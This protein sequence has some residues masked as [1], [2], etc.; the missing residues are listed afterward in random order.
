MRQHLWKPQKKKRD[1]S[2]S[3]EERKCPKE[4]KRKRKRNPAQVLAG[5]ACILIGCGCFFYPNFR[6]WRTQQEVDQIIEDFDKIYADG[7]GQQGIPETE[8]PTRLT[9]PASAETPQAEDENQNLPTAQ[10]QTEIQAETEESKM[11]E[12]QTE[13]PEFQPAVYQNLYQAMKQYNT[14]LYTNGQKIVDVWS[15]SQ[16]PF[17]LPDLTDSIIGYIEIPDM[18]IRLPLALGASDENLEKGAAVL[19]QT[20]MPIGGAN[21]NCVIAGHRGWEGSAY[22]QYIENM[23][24]GSKVYITNPWQTLVYECTDVKVINP[25]DVSSILI[26]DG[27]DMVTLFTCHPYMLGGGPY[28]YL[29]FCERV[30]TKERT[31]AGKIE[32]P[33]TENPPETAGQDM[34]PETKNRAEN[35]STE[36]TATTENT[37]QTGK[38]KAEYALTKRK[39]KEATGIDLLALEQTLRMIL[40]IVLIAVTA[41]IIITEK[42][43]LFR[44]QKPHNKAKQATRKKRKKRRRK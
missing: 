32:N 10:T 39:E 14:G 44:K 42:T 2:S 38:N 31:K 7:I 23:K 13:Q 27:K 5:G 4:E 21:T 43:N 1:S 12:A 15:Y 36:T 3:N 29:V 26:Q 34:E 18:K 33:K 11:P 41:M 37:G 20:S 25:D 19:S 17:D 16:Q 8:Q 22:F 35:A 9:E 24:K 6:E 28:R 40:P 30:D